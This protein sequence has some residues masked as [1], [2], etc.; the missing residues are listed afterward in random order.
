MNTLGKLVCPA[1]RGT[2][3]EVIEHREGRDTRGVFS[4]RR[5][6]CLACDHR[7]TTEER[8]G[9]APPGRQ[10]T[11]APGYALGPPAGL[12]GA[13]FRRRRLALGLTQ[14]QAAARAGVSRA[15][16]AQMEQPSPS[17][18]H[19]AVTRPLWLDT[20]RALTQAEVDAARALSDRN[21]GAG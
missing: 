2:S 5:R 16:Y 7:W 8:V 18:R 10:R 14:E 13:D 4:R 6:R 1:C 21:G 15:T 12:T 11:R 20:D 9:E 3:Q 19:I 17:R